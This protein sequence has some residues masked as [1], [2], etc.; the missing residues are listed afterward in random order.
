[1]VDHLVGAPKDDIIAAL[2]LPTPAPADVPVLQSI[3]PATNDETPTRA[4][5]A[6]STKLPLAGAGLAMPSVLRQTIASG[7][8]APTDMAFSSDGILFYTER[9]QGLFVQRPGQPAAPLFAPKELAAGG[10][11]GM[12]S[13]A[14]DPDFTRNRFVFIFVKTVADGVDAGRVVRLTLD[15]TSAKV[16]DRREILIVVADPMMITMAQSVVRLIKPN[17]VRPKQHE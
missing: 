10:S 6:G 2:A 1:M 7:L 9:L 13:V 8:A 12:L 16:I 14:V 11:L 4:P 5:T 3:P 15:E 17:V